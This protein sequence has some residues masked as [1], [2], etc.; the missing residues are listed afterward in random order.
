[1]ETEREVRVARW[2]WRGREVT[3]YESFVFSVEQ[4]DDLA[5]PPPPV[6]SV[7]LNKREWAAMAAVRG[8][9]GQWRLPWRIGT[10][11]LWEWP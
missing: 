9:G 2:E 7:H 1:M 11:G 5:S 3:L 8:R 4:G 10:E 6:V